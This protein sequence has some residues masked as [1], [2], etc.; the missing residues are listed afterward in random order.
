[1]PPWTLRWNHLSRVHR[2][3]T[4]RAGADNLGKDKPVVFV[5]CDRSEEEA[6]MCASA[7]VERTPVTI[8][9][10]V[11][12]EGVQDAE[13]LAEA[14]NFP[15]K[16]ADELR[17]RGAVLFG[18]DDCIWTV[19]QK[20]LF[21]DALKKLDYVACEATPEKCRDAGIDTL[22]TWDIGK[23]DAKKRVK[24]FHMLPHLREAASKVPGERS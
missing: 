15:H 9:A 22:P 1:M 11:A 17:A 13:S 20:V 7:Q 14:A 4:T 5:A 18:Q 16:V 3:P 24:G 19:R 10:G 6:K 21:G 12:Y 8:I 23:G 2:L